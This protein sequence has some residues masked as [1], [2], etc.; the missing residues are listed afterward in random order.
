MHV[1][2]QAMKL[3]INKVC[4][5]FALDSNRPSSVSAFPVENDN[6]VKRSAEKVNYIF[7]I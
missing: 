5:Q 6:G 7:L 4:V 3:Y 2:N 1:D